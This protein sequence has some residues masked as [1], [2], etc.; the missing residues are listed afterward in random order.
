MITT[1]KPVMTAAVGQGGHVFSAYTTTDQYGQSVVLSGNHKGQLIT[2]TDASGRTVTLRYTGKVGEVDAYVT[3]TTTGANGQPI[4]YTSFAVVGPTGA[5]ATQ[6]G[7]NA[8]GNSRSPGLQGAAAPT[9]RF[10]GEV[11]ALV[12]GAVGV[13][14]LL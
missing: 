7:D 13:M 9:A 4:T 12:G 8:G 14:A 11:A 3:R 5:A 2:T 6:N 10:A 1:A